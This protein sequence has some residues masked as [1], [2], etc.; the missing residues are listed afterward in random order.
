MSC[1]CQ[2][3]N[4]RIYDDDDDDAHD[5]TAEV[6]QILPSQPVAWLQAGRSIDRPSWV[7][8]LMLHPEVI[9]LHACSPPSQHPDRSLSFSD[10]AQR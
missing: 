2:L 7:W 1:V 5:S 3:L 4:K 10:C 8:L 9:S 6:R